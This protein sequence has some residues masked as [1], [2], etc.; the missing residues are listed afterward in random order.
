RGARV[1]VV[2]IEGRGAVRTGVPDLENRVDRA[3]GGVERRSAARGRRPPIPDR[4]ADTAVVEELIT[5]LDS[6][7]GRRS[8]DSARVARD[9]LGAGELVVRRPRRSRSLRV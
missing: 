3:A 1:V 6:R 7:A 4:D 5:R 2:R 8:R 9:V